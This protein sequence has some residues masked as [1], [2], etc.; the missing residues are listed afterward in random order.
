MGAPILILLIGT[1]MK[2]AI[3]MGHGAKPFDSGAVSSLASEEELIRELTSFIQRRLTAQGH[4]V[5][6]VNITSCKSVRDSLLQRCSAAN[7]WGADFFVSIHF[8]AYQDTDKAMGCE[9]LAISKKGK[10]MAANVV[11]AIVGLGFKNRGVKD[12]DYLFVL[13]NTNMPAILI[14]P[15]FIDSSADINLL[16][17]IGYLKLG[18]AIADA[19]VA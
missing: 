14:E 1:K 11:N 19:I 10:N 17:E 9:V 8:N 6:V 4:T 18:N 12:G 13:R 16:R 2:I 5:N 15:C 3:D 7:E